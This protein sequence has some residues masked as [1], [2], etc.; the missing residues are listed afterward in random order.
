MTSPNVAQ[1]TRSVARRS[2]LKLTGKLSAIA[3]LLAVPAAF[4]SNANPSTAASATAASLHSMKST[5]DDLS[6]QDKAILE[7]GQ[8]T[9]ES[10]DNG[11]FTGRVLVNASMPEAWQVL[12]DYDN[13]EQFLPHIENS[14]LL[15]TNGDR[16]QFEQINVVP[17]LPF[18]TSRST[19][20]IESTEH[21]PQRVDFNLVEGDLDALQGVWSLEPI[22]DQVL[23]THQVSI[24]PGS[25]SPKGIFFSTYRN[26]LEDSL[27]A[28]KVEAERRAG[29]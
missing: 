19:I 1:A 8:V 16:N 11:Q 29:E 27:G 14:R 12:T 6:A 21:Y 25:G 24:D 22:G 15:E 20:V 23:V 13:F 2:S 5:L 7:S 28:A 26:V 18:V 17:I 4:V 3:L 10:D 9:I